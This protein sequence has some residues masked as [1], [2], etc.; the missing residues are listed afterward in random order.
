MLLPQQALKQR[1]H[2][3]TFIFI[4]TQQEMLFYIKLIIVAPNI[5]FSLLWGNK[6]NF[7]LTKNL[8]LIIHRDTSPHSNHFHSI[9]KV[10]AIGKV[11][12]N[13]NPKLE[14][15]QAVTRTRTL[16]R[17]DAYRRRLVQNGILRSRSDLQGREY[18]AKF[19]TFP[20]KLLFQRVI[21]K[22]DYKEKNTHCLRF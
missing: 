21:L 8:H 16:E 18:L 5:I 22:Y 1:Y 9:I 6:I 17:R 10:F 12:R 14:L 13:D 4:I 20:E 3:R 7:F 2:H 11:S 19:V 15:V